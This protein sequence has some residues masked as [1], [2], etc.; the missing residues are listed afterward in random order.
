MR[1]AFH[2]GAL[3]AIAL[4]MATACG[5]AQASDMWASTHTMKHD[6]GTATAGSLFAPGEAVHIAVSLHIRNQADMDALTSALASGRTTRHLTS[7]EFMAHY[8]PSQAQV[9]AVVAHL[10]DAGFTNIEVSKNH[11]LVSADGTAAAVQ[12]G[13]NTALRHY[14]VDG[15]D[16]Y[17]NTAD[18]QVPA[19][20]AGLVTAVHGL[21]NVHSAHTMNRPLVAGTV[22]AAAA[23]PFVKVGHAATD[24]SPIYD[25]D[26]LPPASRS[27]IGI[28]AQGDVSPAIADLNTLASEAGFPTPVTR[29]VIA[30]H[31][32]SD[33]S[34]E[35]EWDIDSQSSLASAGGQAASVTFYV[36]STLDDAPLVAA[37]NAAVTDNTAKAINVSLGE[38]E[39]NAQQSGHEAAVDAIY[40][41][42]VA[43]GQMFSVSSGD[44]GSFQCGSKFGGGS[45]PAV[46]PF[47]VAVGGTSLNTTGQTVWAGETLW[48]CN[49][50]LGCEFNGGEGGGASKTEQAPQ[51][52]IDSGVLPPGSTARGEPDISFDADPAT[53]LIVISGNQRPQFGGTS[54]ASPIWVGFWVRIE[55]AA[56]NQLGFP[57]PGLYQ[58]SITPKGMK[59]LH[60]ITE[61]SNGGYTTG[62]GWDQAS[63]FG[64]IDIAKFGQYIRKHGGL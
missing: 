64:S 7:A 17:A 6:V 35:I 41:I 50:A 49:G 38:C 11:M 22:A 57:A 1:Q 5:G 61:G 27:V 14:L 43:Q 56:N 42:A 33:T 8:A 54:L 34:N 25:A 48:G 24:F 55:S 13:F 30:D 37:Y 32:S 26:S 53:G 46:S 9:D 47:A 19:H 15:R 3:G 31:A 23:Q 16:R 2:P 18:A 58:A 29:V 21:Q 59:Y 40:Q 52:Q 60:D 28:I 51:W 10:R 62:P 39:I 44:S 4:A 63:G 20:L 45:F 12:A 36:A